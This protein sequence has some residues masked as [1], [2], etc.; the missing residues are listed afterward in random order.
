MSAAPVQADGASHLP[1]PCRRVQMPFTARMTRKH[2]KNMLSHKHSAAEC[3]FNSSYRVP[4][5]R[6][7]F[8]SYPA[9]RHVAT[10]SSTIRSTAQSLEHI[11]FISLANRP[12]LRR[13]VIGLFRNILVWGTRINC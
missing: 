13:S 9:K 2:E 3:P 6:L 8:L 1:P 7:C 4:G 12:P 10:S 5:P 11:V